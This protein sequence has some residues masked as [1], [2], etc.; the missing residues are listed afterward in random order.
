MGDQA[1]DIAIV[2]GVASS[3]PNKY[4]SGAVNGANAFAAW[5][6]AQKY[7]TLLITD[8]S[9]DVTMPIL[10]ARIEGVLQASNAPIHRIIVYFAGHGL[11]RELEEGLWLLS[12]WRKELRAVAVEVL[13]RRLTM[14]GPQQICI[15]SDACRSLPANVDQADLVPDSVLGAGTT[16][17]RSHRSDR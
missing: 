16:A 3:V 1:R 15:M 6:K 10:R 13:K 9:G 7:E 14:Y 8:E 17:G 11:I 12:D 5:A 4:L 2:I